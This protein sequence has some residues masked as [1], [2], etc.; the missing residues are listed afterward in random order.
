MKK[1]QG[2]TLI[3]IALILSVGLISSSYLVVEG[4]KEVKQGAKSLTV[5]GSAKKT[6]ESDVIAWEGSFSVDAADLTTGYTILK[7]QAAIVK[8][9]FEDKGIQPDEITF[10]AVNTYTRNRI[11]DNGVYTNII[12]SYNLSQTVKINS[13]RVLEVA[14]VGRNATELIEQGIN[15][16][17]NAPQYFYSKLA[18]LKIEMIGLATADAKSR[19]EAMVAVTGNKIGM[20]ESARVGVFQITSLYSNEVDDYGINDTYSYQKEITAVVTCDFE[21]K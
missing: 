4:V 14:E 10:S 20:L 18:D 17:S 11:L 13:T 6:I 2:W 8:K 5:T 7:E 1:I 15:F 12:D 16:T 19:G 3:A 21:V 9:Y